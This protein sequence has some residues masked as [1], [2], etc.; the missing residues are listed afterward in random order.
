MQRVAV[1]GLDA[2]EPE[3]IEQMIAAGELPTLARLQ[4]SGARCRLASEAT[5]RSGRVWET[6][7]TGQADF[8]SAALFDPATYSSY[9]VGSRKK[10]PFYTKIPDLNLLALDVP[11]MSL[12]YDM[13]GAQVIWGGHDAG[14]PRA[15]RPAGLVKQIDAKFG[16]HPAFHNDFNCAWHHEPSINMLA[17]ALIEGSRRRVKIIGWLMEQFPNWNLFMTVLSEAHSAGEMFWHGVA[18]E[19]P[20]SGTPSA[21]VARQRLFDVYRELDRSV[22]GMVALMPPETTVVVC[23]L[24]GMEANDYDVPS[25]ALLPELLYRA[26][27]RRPLLRG[28]RQRSWKMQGCPPIIP[29]DWLKWHDYMKI[30][31]A[32]GPIHRNWRKLQHALR[33]RR[34]KVRPIEKLVVPIPP[35]T[36]QPPDQ[37]AEPRWLLNWQ[38]T[39]WYQKY[40]PQMRAFALPVFYDG[41][42]RIN[43]R[44]R[45]R[46]GLVHATDYRQTCDWVE[47]LLSQCR[48]VRDGTRAMANVERLRGADPL[49]SDGP[50]AD[51]VIT[52][53]KAIDAITHP[54]LGLIG[55]FPFRRTGG[56]TDRGF[57]YIVG[58]AIVQR[59]LGQRDALQLTP[60]IVSLLGHPS[61]DN[62]IFERGARA[63]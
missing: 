5:W 37:I 24:H 57:A 23:S 13:P 26:R 54:Q 9:Q 15:S 43:L 47:Q 62:T 59:D 55:P 17:D 61:Q 51:L 14:Y 52:W 4:H 21:P 27:F 45:E 63:A 46:D 44:G 40:W 39:C 31:F 35:E 19:H 36:E 60:T 6:M 7:L 20:L 10:P 38:I 2:A 33:I 16:I 22:A 49:N 8:P 42:V 11:Y 29:G 3:L 18:R 28:S 32:A 48:N 30:H 58:P 50:D 41:R 53:N 1:I 12:W 56:H 34:G 25:M